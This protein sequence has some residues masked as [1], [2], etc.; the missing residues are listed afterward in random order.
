MGKKNADEGI[1]I[2]KENRE[3][4]IRLDK[5]L[6]LNKFLRNGRHLDFGCGWGFFTKALA[7]RYPKLKI[8]GIDKDSE[9]IENAA[10]YRKLGNI[11]YICA[12]RILGKYSSISLKLVLHETDNLQELLGDI[13]KALKKSG[14]VII[15]DFR[16]TS[17]KTFKKIFDEDWGKDYDFD[18]E[19]LEHNKW[20]LKEFDKIMKGAGFR[21]IMLKDDRYHFLVYLGEKNG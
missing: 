18:K 20:N 17:K 14:K 5:K 3:L 6:K 7:E 1:R 21:R 15:Y 4:L 9:K 12:D 8:D 19:Y 10:A 2:E 13:Y 16:K 11:R